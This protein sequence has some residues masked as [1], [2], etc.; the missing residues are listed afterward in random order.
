[1][2]FPHCAGPVSQYSYGW[3]AEQ[4]MFAAAGY[5]VLSVNPRGSTGAEI[6]IFTPC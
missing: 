5:V 1:M 4:H 6:A 3:S 2:V